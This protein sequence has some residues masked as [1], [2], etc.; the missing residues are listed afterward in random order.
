MLKLCESFNDLDPDME[1]FSYRTHFRTVVEDTG[2]R[3][4][5]SCPNDFRDFYHL[6]TRYLVAG[7]DRLLNRVFSNIKVDD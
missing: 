7:S 3:I 5:H 1:F 2:S 4:F 6:M